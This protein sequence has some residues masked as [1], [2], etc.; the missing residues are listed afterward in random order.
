MHKKAQG[1]KKGQLVTTI[2]I[3]CVL[4]AMAIGINGRAR[5]H[6]DGD[7]DV[8]VSGKR[9]IIKGH[10]ALGVELQGAVP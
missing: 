4:A 5:G 8:I 7:G 10:P 1:R 6:L 3:D 2:R 9:I